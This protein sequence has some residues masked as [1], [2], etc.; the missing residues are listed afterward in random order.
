MRINTDIKSPIEK[1]LFRKGK[2]LLMGILNITPDSFY[3]GGCYIS[4]DHAVDKAVEM[5]KEGAD[6]I[7]LGGE[8]SR[9]GS[10]GISIEEEMKRVLPVVIRLKELLTV[11]VSLDTSRSEVL[12][13]ALA[14]G[15][16][17]IVND[18][19]AGLRDPRIVDI[20]AKN[21]LTMVIMHMKGTPGNMQESPAYDNVVS[22][23][24]DFFKERIRA[25][26]SCGVKSEKIILDP[27]L[28]F[29][30]RIQDNLAILKNLHVFKSLGYPLLIGPSRKSFIGELTGEKP[31]E[32]R[33]FGTAAAVSYAIEAG[34]DIVRVHDVKE[35]KDVM[36]IIDSIK[37]YEY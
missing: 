2:S 27:G 23:I 26:K 32:E 34:A 31:P 36:H 29:G 28:G 13:E 30:K 16:I 4:E 20:A 9:P 11:P 10:E 18:I 15:R 12:E 1:H 14:F 25:L 8:S 22:E 33:L 5:E 3:D 24:L 17:S 37:N 19:Y 21:N 7:D 6:I 35:I